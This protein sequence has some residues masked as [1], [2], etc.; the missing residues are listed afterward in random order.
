MSMNSRA[1]WAVK[2]R[3]VREQ[4]EIVGLILR[5]REPP[6]PP[7]VIHLTRVSPG[8]MDDDNSI[9]ALKACRDAIA[10]WIGID[11]GLLKF[12]Y[13]QR[14]GPWSVEMRIEHE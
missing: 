3:K 5:R 13:A 7:M 2:A 10:A 12:E 4:R 1:H 11:D 6:V 14:K 8:L 9:T